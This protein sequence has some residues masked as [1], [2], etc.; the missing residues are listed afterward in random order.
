LW[1]LGTVFALS[2]YSPS[3]LN[4]LLLF[5]SAISA[6]LN[7]VRRFLLRI[8]YLSQEYLSE[9]ESRLVTVQAIICGQMPG[10]GSSENRKFSGKN[11]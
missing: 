2:Q 4:Y 3:S 9:R 8:I 7:P 1:A 5:L 10:G 6:D 11:E